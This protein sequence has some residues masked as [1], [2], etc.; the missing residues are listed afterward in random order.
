MNF[1]SLYVGL[2]FGNKIP[3]MSKYSRM[4]QIEF[5]KCGAF[6]NRHLTPLIAYGFLSNDPAIR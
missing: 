4:L 2:F 5:Q 3:I 1:A 6:N